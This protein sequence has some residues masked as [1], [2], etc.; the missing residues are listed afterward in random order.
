MTYEFDMSVV[1]PI[2]HMR[3]ASGARYG[4]NGTSDNSADNIVEG[5]S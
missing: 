4:H 5:R 1:L 2:A 3:R